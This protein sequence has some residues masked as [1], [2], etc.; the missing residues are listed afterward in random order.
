[1]S[2]IKYKYKFDKNYNPKYVN[3]ALGGINPQ[4]EVV[5]NFYL[6]R[7]SI[8]NSQTYSIDENGLGNI[9]DM[10]PKDYNTSFVRFVESGI[11]MDYKTAKEIHRWL[12]EHLESF[13]KSTTK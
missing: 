12:G 8:P 5:I 6:E 11:L 3:G 2:T 4:G 10:E 13:E 7:I 9:E 1:M